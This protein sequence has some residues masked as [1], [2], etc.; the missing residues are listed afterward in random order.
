M[1][2]TVGLQNRG[3]QQEHGQQ[4]NTSNSMSSFILET[5]KLSENFDGTEGIDGVCTC[6]QHLHLKLFFQ[7]RRGSNVFRSVGQNS[8]RFCDI[9]REKK[10]CFTFA[11]SSLIN[12]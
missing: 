10:Q 9:A 8:I 6:S 1:S 4:K 5:G 12:K 11:S 7:E 3:R 2:E